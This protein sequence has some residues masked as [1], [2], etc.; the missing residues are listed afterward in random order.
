MFL[1]TPLPFLG[2]G[3]LGLENDAKLNV[4]FIPIRALRQLP[5]HFSAGT[6]ALSE[7]KNAETLRKELF[8]PFLFC[9]HPSWEMGH[10]LPRW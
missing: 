6:F 9:F 5:L 2:G 3:N 7:Q 4:T 10:F 8:T 1:C